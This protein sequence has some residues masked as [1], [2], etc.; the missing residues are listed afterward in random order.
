MAY[1]AYTA[2]QMLALSEAQ[3]QSVYP[4]LTSDKVITLMTFFKWLPKNSSGRVDRD[5]IMKACEYDVDGD[6]VI[7]IAEQATC[8]A[9]WLADFVAQDTDGS[10]DISPHELLEYNNTL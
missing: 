2:D 8:A 3:I 6:G 10:N 7:T 4:S 1:A 9:V 5:G